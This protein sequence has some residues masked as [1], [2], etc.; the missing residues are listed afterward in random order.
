MGSLTCFAL[1]RVHPS[2]TL[3]PPADRI[4]T[5]NVPGMRR[6]SGAKSIITKIFHRSNH[7]RAREIPSEYFPHMYFSPPTL[8]PP[9]ASASTFPRFCANA[10]SSTCVICLQSSEEA[11][12]RKYC[13]CDSESR[14]LQ[15]MFSL[16]PLP[17]CSIRQ[18]GPAAQR[19]LSALLVYLVCLHAL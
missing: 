16:S 17:S 7:A 9:A 5:G 12:R 10:W 13:D 14:I 11:K 18:I 3:L 2:G 6:G 8:M 4:G 15:T 1:C 19:M